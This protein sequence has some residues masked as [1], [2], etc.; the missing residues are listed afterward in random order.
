MEELREIYP[1]VEDFIS[2][3]AVARLNGYACGYG[4]EEA[5]NS[6]L[7]E[8]GLSEAGSERLLEIVERGLRPGCVS[9]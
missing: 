5:L 1:D 4:S 9:P 3:T 8:L 7:D 2:S 6:G